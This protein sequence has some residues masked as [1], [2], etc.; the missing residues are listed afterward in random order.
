V[1]L[2]LTGTNNI[3]KVFNMSQMVASNITTTGIESGSLTK[4][5]ACLIISSNFVLVALS[6]K[7]NNNM[8]S[9]GEGVTLKKQQKQ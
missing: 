6:S 3:K 1:A 7:N 5:G 9:L 2:S 8:C 4:L